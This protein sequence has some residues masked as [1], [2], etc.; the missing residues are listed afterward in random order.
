VAPGQGLRRSLCRG[1]PGRNVDR[2]AQ[3]NHQVGKVTAHAD[4]VMQDLQRRGV[5]VRGVGLKLHPPLHPVA[6]GLH[7]AVALPQVAEFSHSELVQ[8]V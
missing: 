3:C 4:L 1:K 5:A 7:A 8:L 2:P 6:N